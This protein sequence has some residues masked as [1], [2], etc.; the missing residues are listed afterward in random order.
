MNTN[1][2]PAMAMAQDPVAEGL[3]MMQSDAN[4][5]QISQPTPTPVTETSVKVQQPIET[6]VPIVA[7]KQKQTAPVPVAT[8]QPVQQEQPS[9]I[10]GK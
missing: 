8:Q 3:N 2:S 1:L 9:D 5:Q 7:N 6:Q 4:K 10:V